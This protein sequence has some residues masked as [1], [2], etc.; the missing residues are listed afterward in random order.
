MVKTTWAK[1]FLLLELLRG[2][3]L[4][5]ILE[6]AEHQK[7]A[8]KKAVNRLDVFFMLKKKK[9]KKSKNEWESK[10]FL[11]GSEIVL[12]VRNNFHS[13]FGTC[14]EVPDGQMHG[15]TVLSGQE[16]AKKMHVFWSKMSMHVAR[17][18]AKM[19]RFRAITRSRVFLGWKLGSELFELLTL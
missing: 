7:K 1:M 14:F 16:L 9:W 18:R 6:V 19:A 2:G 12:D 8:I 17:Y 13:T 5:S 15:R 4:V 11:N 3:V 10:V